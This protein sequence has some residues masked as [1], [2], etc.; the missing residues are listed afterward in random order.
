MKKEI[1]YAAASLILTGSAALA[2]TSDI[3]SH[4]R[5]DFYAPGKHQ[6]YAWCADGRD[7][8]VAQNG[9]TA[10]DAEGKLMAS[11]KVANSCHLTWQGRIHS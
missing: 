9:V 10:N 8:L 7:R 5:S 1:L 6:F 3:A 2:A 11:Q 4:R